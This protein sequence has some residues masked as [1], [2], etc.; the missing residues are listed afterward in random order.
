MFAQSLYVQWKWNRDFL[1]FFTAIAFAAPLIILW[2]ALP[3][4][5]LSS[6]R[7]LVSVGGVVGAA[8][9]VIAVVA[10]MTV[11]WHGYGIDERAG[12]IYAMS[13]PITRSR[14]LAIRAC[15][16]AIMLALPALGV[17]IGAMLAAGQIEMPPSLH[18]YAGSLATKALL[19]SWLAHALMFALR[20]CARSRS[21]VVLIILM[22]GLSGVGI[23]TSV[24]P[25]SRGMVVRAG[26]FLISNP[27]PFG[28][29][30]SRWTL[31]DV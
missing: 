21:K 26:D 1:G 4:L 19:T 25:G 13:L 8:T 11:A 28:V 12:H 2:I 29:L 5:G 10:G 23:A 3:H 18:A 9:A 16:A 30:F 15:A 22:F 31:I 7:E 6:G 24:A 27:G 14:A 20:Y 17:W